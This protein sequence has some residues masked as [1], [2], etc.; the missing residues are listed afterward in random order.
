MVK[1]IDIGAVDLE[2]DSMTGQI[3]VVSFPLR[4]FFEAVLPA[5]SRGD[6]PRHSSY[7]S[8]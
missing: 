2:F 5:L 7:V 1:D 3:G 8:A 4:R 6:E